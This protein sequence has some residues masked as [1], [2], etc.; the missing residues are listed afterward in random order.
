MTLIESINIKNDSKK[1]PFNSEHTSDLF[2]QIWRE[3]FIAIEMNFSFHVHI[4][5][6]CHMNTI[7]R[8]TSD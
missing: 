6:K 1:L 2:Y 5:T 7:L 8:K 4:L 3:K